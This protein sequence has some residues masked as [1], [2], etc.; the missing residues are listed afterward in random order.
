MSSGEKDEVLSFDI[1][2]VRFP[3]VKEVTYSKM[4]STVLKFA[5]LGGG[6]FTGDEIKDKMKEVGSPGLVLQRIV[7]FL[8]T[9]GFIERS[10]FGKT[11]SFTH[12]LKPR[13]I[14]L[15]KEK[16]ANFDSIFAELCKT[17]PSYLVIWEY[18]K[19]EKVK[20]FTKVAFEGYLSNVLN[21]KHS[22]GGLNAWLNALNSVGLISLEKDFVSLEDITPPWEK[23]VSAEKQLRKEPQGEMLRGAEA[24]PAP[25][26]MSINVSFDMDYRLPPNLYRDTLK[27]LEK[28]RAS[29][30]P[31]A[32]TKREEEK[33]STTKKE[34]AQ[35]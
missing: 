20:K 5:E 14:P 27:W 28:M 15:L 9:L 21:L 4:K 31:I 33:E 29:G 17:S 32:V 11:G 10:R 30:V 23:K 2:K 3:S 18:S 13:L 1:S 25:T 6:P 8:R 19:K 12:K 16:P 26:P 22:K 34:T 35:D 7:P 24:M